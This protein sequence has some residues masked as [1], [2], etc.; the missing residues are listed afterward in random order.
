[1]G[2]GA[3]SAEDA[4]TSERAR[5]ESLTQELAA[6]AQI[7]NELEAT[8]AKAEAEQQVVLVAIASTYCAII[9]AQSVHTKL[10][11]LCVCVLRVAATS[12]LRPQR[13]TKQ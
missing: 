2:G 10:I 11:V 1:M 6:V 4:L 5:S 13:L 12:A 9:L 8:A 7:V 3:E